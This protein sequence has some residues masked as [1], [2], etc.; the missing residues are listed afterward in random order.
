MKKHFKTLFVDFANPKQ[1]EDLVNM[2]IDY[3]G[4]IMGGGNP[5]ERGLAEKSIALM[6]EKNH[7]FSFLCYDDKK[8][9]GFANCF[10]TVATFAGKTAI[11]IHDLAVTKSHRGLG[12]STRLLET[13]A[14]YG[15]Q[16]GYYKITL[17]VLQGN[18]PARKSYEK[19][20]FNAFQLD[21]Q[22][23]SAL[24]LQKVL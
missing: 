8:A 23:G 3:S 22:M 6:A 14:E 12:A 2:L 24:F 15:K 18:V 21:P 11:N 4:D 7:T 9:I 16:H 20:G 13:I 17:E 1:R 5:L 19:S 10:E